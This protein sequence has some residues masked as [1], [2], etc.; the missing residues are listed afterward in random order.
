MMRASLSRWAV[1][2]L[3]I[4]T[5][6]CAAGPASL[7]QET[8]EPA[9]KK[10]DEK[11]DDAAAKAE[12]SAKR[13]RVILGELSKELGK[14]KTLKCRF[15]QRKYLAVFEKEVVSRG[16]LAL[17]PPT[18]LRWEYEHP[19][20]SILIV[21]GGRARQERTS[22]R[23]KKTV[24][25]FTLAEDRITSIT[26][27]QVFLWTR[28]DFAK[29]RENYELA[30]VSEKPLRISATPRDERMRKVVRSVTLQFAGDRK[31][32][33]RIVLN[34]SKDASTTIEFKDVEIDPEL[35]EAVFRISD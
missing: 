4:A 1:A 32:L 5:A 27:E 6:F 23:G 11:K 30:L 24:R 15:E 7:A 25:T 22:R 35:A 10:G 8:D 3:L 33:T 31:A 29:A 14:V 20:K 17:A 12:A 18:K 34:E 28:G 9:A 16:R 26:A 21:N 2:T 13:L 19:I